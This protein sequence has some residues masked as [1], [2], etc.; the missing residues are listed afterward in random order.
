M[1]DNIGEDNVNNVQELNDNIGDELDGDHIGEHP[2]ELA[3]DNEEPIIDDALVL[4]FRNLINARQADNI[5][6]VLNG[7]HLVNIDEHLRELGAG[8]GEPIDGD[9]VVLF[10]NVNGEANDQNK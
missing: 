4:L 8:D 10:F 3:E 7:G 2:G 6:D 9:D 1:N 5:G